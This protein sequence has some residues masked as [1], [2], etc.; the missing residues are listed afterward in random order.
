MSL[1]ILL[2]GAVVGNGLIGFPLGAACAWLAKRYRLQWQTVSLASLLLAFVAIVSITRLRSGEV[3]G[4]TLMGA[5]LCTPLCA[6]GLIAGAMW[7]LRRRR[8]RV[9]QSLPEHLVRRARM[10]GGL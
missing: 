5:A 6:P 9:Q 10:S 1:L 7:M 2:A 3:D 8:L 4:I